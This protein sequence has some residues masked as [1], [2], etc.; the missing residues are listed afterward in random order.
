MTPASPSG[1][2]LALFPRASLAFDAGVPIFANSIGP[3]AR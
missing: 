2:K 3:C 1:L